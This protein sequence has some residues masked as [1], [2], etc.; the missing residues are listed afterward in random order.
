MQVKY[1]TAISMLHRN[2]DI[3][4]VCLVEVEGTRRLRLDRA[5]RVSHIR[6][7]PDVD[8]NR[9]KLSVIV[10]A[11]GTTASFNTNA[12]LIVSAF[13]RAGAF[14]VT[15]HFSLGL[16]AGQLEALDAKLHECKSVL[17]TIS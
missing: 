1:D 13:D 2:I 12:L 16:I 4:R 14:D 5:G 3:A 9:K 8:G 15:I 11:D 6:V 7:T 17:L 10:L